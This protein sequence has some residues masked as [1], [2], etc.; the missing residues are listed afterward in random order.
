M[1]EAM[2]RL[3]LIMVLFCLALP[4]SAGVEQ[5]LG[6]SGN[7]V[8]PVDGKI[9]V[10]SDDGTHAALVRGMLSQPYSLTWVETYVAEENRPS[11]TTVYGEMLASLLPQ[12]GFVLGAESEEGAFVTVPVRLSDGRYLTLSFHDDLLVALTL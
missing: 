8:E 12:T 9:G 1:M 5:S 11:F 6:L 10:L 4:L 3:P 2:R 7:K